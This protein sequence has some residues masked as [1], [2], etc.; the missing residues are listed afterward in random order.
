MK[1]IQV[2][3][4]RALVEFEPIPQCTEA[5]FFIPEAFRKPSAYGTIVALGKETGKRGRGILAE[6]KVGDR[7]RVDRSMGSASAGGERRI[8]SVLDIQAVFSNGS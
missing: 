4:N 1:V 8:V 7:V 2:L 3:G 5:G 6:L